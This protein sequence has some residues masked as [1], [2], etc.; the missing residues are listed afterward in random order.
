[1][2]NFIVR[3]NNGLFKSSLQRSA[4]TL[5]SKPIKHFEIGLQEKWVIWGAEKAKFLDVIGNKFLPEPP[6]SLEYG[7]KK[8]SFPRVEFVK[9][10]GVIPTAHLSARY[11]YFKD[12][13]DQT[14]EKFIKDNT[15]GSLAVDYEV[16]KTS[17][18][19]DLNLYS[20]L[21]RDLKLEA[22]EHR[23]AMGLSNGQMR[24]ARLARSLLKEPDLTLLDDPFL[25]LD[26][27]ATDTISNLIGSYSRSCI[28]IGLRYQDQIPEW[29]THVCCVDENGIV[30]QGRKHE[31]KELIDE[32]RKR[33]TS[34]NKVAKEPEYQIKDLVSRHPLAQVPHHEIIKM[35][36]AF[37]LKGLTVSY[38][39][40]PVLK[41]LHW[42]VTPKSKWHVKGDNG[43][44][45]S[46]L[47]SLLTADH[48]QS[49]NS[50]VVED[51]KPR[52]TGSTDYFTINRGVSMS[53][54]ELHA[55]FVK[56]SRNGLTVLEALASGF[57]ENSSN[58]FLPYHSNLSKGQR[59]TLKIFANYFGIDALLSRKFEDIS[60]S[61]QKLVLF[62]R[63]LLKMPKTLILDEA[64]SAM[65]T[66]PRQR[67]HEFLE[68]WPGTVFVV[69]HVPEETPRCDHYLR[70]ISPGHYEIGDDTL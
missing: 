23:W 16:S 36:S 1:M 59:E 17:R 3:I 43:T 22:L 68:Y 18:K 31:V 4:P 20:E 19:V 33:Y 62:V 47:L 56:N 34:H 48:P 26:P 6:L 2:A 50:R 45:K 69:S 14:C 51:G 67:C 5:Y 49:W 32:T 39:G 13:F 9:F 29:C 63:C 66:E 41:D 44:G 55:I 38:K 70:L 37:E 27:G 58:N 54:P 15:A 30:F 65:E 7:L 60:V 21:L 10:S 61:D 46:T 12:D 42:K 8:G 25:G 57:Q 28:V 64:F 52:K 53:S 35:P 40:E 11:E 24:R